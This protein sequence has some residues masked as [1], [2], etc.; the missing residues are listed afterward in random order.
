MGGMSAY[1]F[2]GGVQTVLFPW[3]IVIVLEQSAERV[4]I[5]QMLAMM[6]MLILGLFGG[7]TADRK[8]LRRYLMRL[9]VAA[10]ITPL[11]LVALYFSGYLIYEVLVA[12]AI[13]GSALGAFTMPARDS[14]LNRVANT[15]LGGRI[16]QAVTMATGAQFMSQVVGLLIGGLAT[17]V[18]A[19]PLMIAQSLSLMIAAATT[20]K[21]PKAPP[22][23]VHAK[24]EDRPSQIS[25]IRE[26]IDIV[27][28]DENLRSVI[29]MMFFAGILYIGVFMVLFP[30]LI[31]DIYGGGSFEIAFIN[32]C[33][34]GGIGVSS[35]MLTRF[36]PIKR[37][38]RAIM[39]AMCSGSIMMVLVHFHPPLWAVFA[40]ALC[41]GLS[42]GISMSQSRA[43]VQ[44]AATDSHR[45]R[46]L[47]VFQLGMMGG[48]PI[49][50]FGAGFV[51]QALGPLDAVLIPSSC[52][53]VLW[54]VIFF[55][56]NLW[57]IEAG[58]GQATEAA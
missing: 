13:I 10:A 24:P 4:G 20:M 23:V 14:L 16:Q 9:Q 55:G 46:V 56:T 58:T 30:L 50:A 35:M 11:I 12:Y 39:L 34:F 22:S 7:A 40:L 42:S 33:F 31:R 49:G 2:S 29:L 18:G 28:R 53:V 52:M 36:P 32:I 44:I 1:F 51:I 3:L 8:E 45:A 25:Q 37:Q 27:W 26:G 43:I 5:A 57:K 17:I 21:L 48:G 54:L 15:S 38:G 41:W 6:P 19:A 47:S